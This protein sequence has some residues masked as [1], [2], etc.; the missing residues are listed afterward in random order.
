MEK[1]LLCV[2][3]GKSSWLH[4]GFYYRVVRENKDCYFIQRDGFPSGKM[5]SKRHFELGDSVEKEI[6]DYL[7][8]RENDI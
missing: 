1:T 6:P 5:Y 4:P 8:N 2:Y 3:K 7:F